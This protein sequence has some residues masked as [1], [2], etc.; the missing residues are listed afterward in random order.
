MVTE[1]GA[2][3]D[4]EDDV[5]DRSTD[6]YEMST[7]DITEGTEL[8]PG[9]YAWD[10]LG[11]GRRFEM[12]VAWCADRLTPVCVKLPRRDELNERTFDA[13]RRE[14]Q[15]ASS[16]DHPAIPRVFDADLEG[17]RP[18]LVHEFIEGKPLSLVLDDDGPYDGHDLVFLGLQ[19][20]AAL[21]HI[22]RRG[23][24]HLDLK[25]SNV[26]MRGDRAT[27]F[28]FDIALPIGAQRSTNKPRGTHYYMAP[29]QIRCQPAH[30]SMDLFAL[31]ALLYEAA[32][33][34]VAF[35]L[36]TGELP[37][38]SDAQPRVHR[39]NGAPIP[40]IG[41]LAPDLPLPIAAVIDR[42]M[43]IDVEARPA[44]AAESIRL[45]EA[46]LPDDDDRMWPAWVSDALLTDSHAAPKLRPSSLSHLR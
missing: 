28:D 29:E 41:D 9:Y 34:R 23:F 22:H 14:H 31:G 40:P 7:W 18:Y 46:A 42:L 11:V 21:R 33:N 24:V 10:V 32:S 45:L 12:W 26:A 25:P 38:D 6:D 2:K 13:L 43:A 16:F 36:D 27:V 17:P 20:G 37:T 3:D 44:S 39:Q 5:E 19:L 15:A 30:P 35:A 8:A 1:D 4:M